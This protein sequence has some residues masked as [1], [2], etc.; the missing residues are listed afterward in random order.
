M[1][2]GTTFTAGHDQRRRSGTDPL[3]ENL[4]RFSG[5]LHRGPAYGIAAAYAS[6]ATYEWS[7]PWTS[8]GG[9]YRICWCANGFVCSAGRDFK[10]DV[11]ELVVV[12]PAPLALIRTCV[13]GQTCSVDRLTGQ[14]LSP[15]DDLVLLDTCGS[16]VITDVSNVV[17]GTTGLRNANGSIVTYPNTIADV[18]ARQVIA[19]FTHAG[20]GTQYFTNRGEVVA[21]GVPARSGAAYSVRLKE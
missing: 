4:Y 6:G 2:T 9:Q 8:N 11:G 21:T 10:V 19:R 14:H 3:D 13:A 5:G 12:G 16:D 15:A 18:H 20:Q 17:N 7:A 1:G